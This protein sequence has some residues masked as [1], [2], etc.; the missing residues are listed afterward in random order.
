MNYTDDEFV[1]DPIS[2][3]QTI[4]ELTEDE[5]AHVDK[6]LLFC[7]LQ[8]RYDD[9][10]DSILNYTNEVNTEFLLSKRRRY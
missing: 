9:L 8:R 7:A 1:F 3:F 2:E 10:I 4:V 5:F 6:E